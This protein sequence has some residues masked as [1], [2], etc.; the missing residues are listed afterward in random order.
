M[1]EMLRLAVP[2]LVRVTACGELVV[3]FTWVAK[4]RLVGDSVTAGDPAY[5][6]KL[7][8]RD[9]DMSDTRQAALRSRCKRQVRVTT[10]KT[11]TTSSTHPPSKFKLSRAGQ[12]KIRG[13]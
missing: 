5:A 12:I 13:G 4:V 6:G 2:E 11:P 10:D 3:P 7:Q 8:R 1:A 9:T